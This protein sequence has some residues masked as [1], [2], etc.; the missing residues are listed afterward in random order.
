MRC[1]E[2]TLAAVHDHGWTHHIPR[3][4]V[5]GNLALIAGVSPH[6]LMDWMWERFVDGAEWVMAPNVIGMSQYADGGVMATKPYA[7]GGGRGTDRHLLGGDIHHPGGT[8]RIE[9]SQAGGRL[10]RLHGEGT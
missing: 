6:E 8:G 3:L 9:M 5:L 1:V 4:M 10:I 7:A 2:H